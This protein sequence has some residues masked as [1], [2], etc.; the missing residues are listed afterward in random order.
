MNENK[1]Q[2]PQGQA[3]PEQGDFLPANLNTEAA[4]ATRNIQEL[5]GLNTRLQNLYNTAYLNLEQRIKKNQILIQSQ[6]KLQAEIAELRNQ[7][8][9]Y[10]G[11]DNGK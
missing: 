6:E 5:M 8:Q 11:I 9:K 2:A 7:L 10:R 1:E 4:Q 3:S